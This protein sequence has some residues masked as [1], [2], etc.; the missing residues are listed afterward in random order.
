MDKIFDSEFI[1]KINSI[2]NSK[3]SILNTKNAVIVSSDEARIILD[4]QGQFLI[5]KSDL[6][7]HI[8]DFYYVE[9]GSSIKYKTYHSVKALRRGVLSFCRAYH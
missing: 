8:Y 4:W 5:K 1:S 2:L 9:R 3:N 7:E 6:S